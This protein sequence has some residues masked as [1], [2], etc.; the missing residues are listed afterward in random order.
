MP[1]ATKL[2]VTDRTLMRAKYGQAGWAKIRVGV[3]T[4]I[5]ADRRRGITTRLVLVDGATAAAAKQH[6]DTAFASAAPDYL[7]ILGAPDVVAQARLNNLLWTG[8]PDDDPDQFVDTDLPYACDAPLSTSIAAYRG[9]TRVVGRL[10]DLV[11][12]TD[13]G[14]LI[15]LLARAAGWKA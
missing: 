14:Y 13:P 11:G 4:L 15:K 6:I 3:R 7:M 5:A 8:N 1:Q 9:P 12:G 10:P 2:I